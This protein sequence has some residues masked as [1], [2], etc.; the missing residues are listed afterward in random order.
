VKVRHKKR[1][2]LPHLEVIEETE[3]HYIVGA[4]RPGHSVFADVVSKLHYEP[5]PTETWRDVT[6]ECG[7]GADEVTLW[8]EGKGIIAR[9][10]GYR[11][12]KVQVCREGGF[13][14]CD[15]CNMWAFKVEKR[16]P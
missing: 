8:H 7:L 3:K 10:L 12:R 9:S 1:V 11:I 13:M 4:H 16:E 15:K 14:D 5:V 6:G 2:E